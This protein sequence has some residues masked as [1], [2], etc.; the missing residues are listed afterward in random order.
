MVR[1]WWCGEV[2]RGGG[3]LDGEEVVVMILD[4]KISRCIT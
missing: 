4:E 1:K 3:V 2:V